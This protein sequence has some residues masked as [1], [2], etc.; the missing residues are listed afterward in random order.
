M[1][2]P[3]RIDEEVKGFGEKADITSSPVI[4]D[5]E[6]QA[7]SPIGAF[8]LPNGFVDD[9][10]TLVQDVV[11]RELT[12]NEEDIL[13][14][15]KMAVHHRMQLIMENC[16]TQLGHYKPHHIKWS[17]MIKKLPVADR[18]FLMLKIR[19]VS[20]G[21]AYSFTIE[22]PSCQSS[23]HQTVSLDDFIISPMKNPLERVWNG[24]LPRSKKPYVMRVQTGLEEDKVAQAGVDGKDI[25]STVL[26]VRLVELDGVSPVTLQMVKQLGLADRNHLRDDMKS[27]EGDIDSSVDIK[28]PHCM[29][30]F[31]REIDIGDSGFF[32]PTATPKS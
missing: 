29:H 4:E 9:D 26:L 2:T 8:K 32:F 28:C 23:S 27:H 14:S 11:V 22:C 17:Q 15:G 12:G 1:A 6:D 31:K 18:L 3:K 25:L 5:L 21:A 13:T 10:G 24:V 7:K 30:E 20:L 19:T 16:V